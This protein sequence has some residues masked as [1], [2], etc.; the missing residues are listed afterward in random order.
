M[1]VTSSAEQHDERFRSLLDGTIAQLE[2]NSKQDPQRYMQLL[3][4]KLEDEVFEI[5]NEMAKSTPFEGT[6]ELV[7]GQK[8]PDII[9]MNYFGVEVKSTKQNH[10]TTTGNSVLESTRVAD[11]ERIYM[12]F[13]KMTHPIEFKY[14]L[15]QDCLSNV[16]V[17]HSPRYTIDMNLEDGNTVFDKINIDYENIRNSENPVKP[18]KNYYRE[19]LKPGQE[20]WWLDSELTVPE[21][22][23]FRIWNSIDKAE[24]DNF[25][26]KGFALFPELLGKRQDKFD[27]FTLWLSVKHLVLCPN[28]RDVYTAGGKK[29]IIIDGHDL[30]GM[31]SVLYRFVHN[32]DQIINELLAIDLI[33]FQEQWKMDITDRNHLVSIWVSR[34]VVKVSEIYSVNDFNFM[35]WL[36]DKIVVKLEKR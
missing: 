6:I 13:G 21:N 8:F 3:G 29:S 27:Q 31:P 22:V 15:Y 30:I 12:L 18:F 7:S 9:A 5:M 24:R 2:K 25:R 35:E 11:I 28:V 34:V 16:V 17:T 20:L 36:Q 14:R 1:V 4:N 23:I 19:Q 33:V 26:L 10:W 32:I